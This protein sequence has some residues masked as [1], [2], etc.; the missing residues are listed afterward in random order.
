MPIW[1]RQVP[2]EDAT[3]IRLPYQI[4]ITDAHGS[5]LIP[6]QRRAHHRV[7]HHD[8]HHVADQASDFADSA[9]D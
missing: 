7:A 2:L 6:Q 1:M 3:P 9:A 4:P 5:H 8:S